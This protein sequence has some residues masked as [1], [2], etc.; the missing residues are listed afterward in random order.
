[1]YEFLSLF[2]LI[3]Q[4]FIGWLSCAAVVIA[5]VLA[6]CQFCYFIIDGKDDQHENF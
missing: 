6:A 4:H 2:D 1:M 5:V 3:L